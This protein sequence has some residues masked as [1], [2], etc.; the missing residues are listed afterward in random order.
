M[1]ISYHDQTE[2][3]MVVGLL[4]TSKIILL[5]I[6]NQVF[7]KTLKILSQIYYYL[8]QNPSL[9]ALSIVLLIK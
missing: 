5:I 8:N 1:V 3:E 9:W 7:L 6:D 2:T 4:A